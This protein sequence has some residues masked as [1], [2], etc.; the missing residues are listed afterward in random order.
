MRVQSIE[1]LVICISRTRSRLGVRVF[2]EIRS[3]AYTQVGLGIM[4]CRVEQSGCRAYAKGL[5]SGLVGE[6]REGMRALRGELP[7][8]LCHSL[9]ARKLFLEHSSALRCK[10]R[11]ARTDVFLKVYRDEPSRRP[12][13]RHSEQ[14]NEKP[15]NSLFTLLLPLRRPVSLPLLNRLLILRRLSILL[16]QQLT[17]HAL[18]Q[19]PTLI[20]V[21][22]LQRPHPLRDH[23]QVAQV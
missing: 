8:L 13:Q 18:P 14:Q 16:S 9:R 15:A 12:H 5:G 20:V 6:T 10:R 23:Q 21:L 11:D 1:Q 19:L 22:L 2:E 7:N 3:N 17:R 4:L